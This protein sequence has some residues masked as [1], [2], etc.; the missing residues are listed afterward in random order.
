MKLLISLICVALAYSQAIKYELSFP[1]AERHEGEFK[2]TAT[3]L[4]KGDISVLMSRSS[5]GRYALHEFSKNMYHVKAVD[6]KGK[7]LTMERAS[8]HEWKISGHDGTVTFSYTLFANHADGTYAGISDRH[9]HLNAPASLAYF[10]SLPNREVQV[11][12][13]APSD[14]K[15][16][17]QLKRVKAN[18]EYFAPNTY[19]LLDSPIMASNHD[20]RSWNVDGQKITAAV[21]HDGTKEDL[22][23]YFTNTKKVVSELAAVFGEL[24]RFDYGEYTFLVSYMPF[25]KG[26]GME[27]RNSTIVTSTSPITNFARGYHGTMSHE[28]IHAWNV[29]RIRPKN[30]EPFNFQEANVSDL[31]WF[32]EGFTSYYD[33]LVIHRAGIRSFD[34]YV[35]GL[36]GG[37]NYVLLSPGRNYYS[38]AEMSQQA[39]FVDAAKS[40]DEQNKSNTFISYYTGGAV[41]GMGLDLTLRGQFNKTLDGFM[42]LAWKRFGKTETPYTIKELENLLGEYTDS[43]SFAAEFFKNYITGRKI[44]NFN[45][46]LAQA[47]IEIV[48]RFEDDK[49]WIG[50]L[51]YGT[52][53]AGLKI[54]NTV[55]VNSPAYAAGL[56]K[57]DV[58]VSVNSAKTDSVHL[59]RDLIDSSTI[60]DEIIVTI[61]RFGNEI[62]KK[63]TIGKN[64][65]FTLRTYEDLGKPVTDKIK[66]FRASWLGSK[67]TLYKED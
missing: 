4:A 14:W 18:K 53:A 34:Q 38:I 60:G 30:L 15:V 45:K 36:V 16:A 56:V 12:I 48:S 51:S 39:P 24:P 42:Q 23:H 28:F 63:I 1:H 41:V 17:T 22:D 65:A 40:V 61:N 59:I 57:D 5:P 6:S 54:R 46:L 66:A 19:Y 50:N 26:D 3:N 9:A 64:P 29:E 27:H 35:R 52:D 20:V 7:E 62:V 37:M 21:L 44:P 25:V 32:A 13:N 11:F 8:L 33:D 47:G 31:L 49:P 67:G 10:P 55:K 58:I 43:R 2:I